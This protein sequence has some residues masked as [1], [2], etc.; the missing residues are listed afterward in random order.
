MEGQLQ[1]VSC[2][3]NPAHVIE[4]RR[5]QYHIMKCKK[6]RSLMAFKY[7]TVNVLQSFLIIELASNT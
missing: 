7:Q 2:P 4:P 3:F 1:R 5:L 6:V